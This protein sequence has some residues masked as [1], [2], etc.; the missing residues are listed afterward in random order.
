MEASLK[1]LPAS[2]KRPLAFQGALTRIVKCLLGILV[3]VLA[4]GC[5]GNPQAA[6][7][8]R[9]EEITGSGKLVT[10]ELSLSGF[11]GVEV[12]SAFKVDVFQSDSY[13]VLVT[14]D[15]NIIDRVDAGVT[16]GRLTL[17][18]S[19]GSYL[20][21]TY[22]AS[23]GMPGL[24]SLELSEATTGTVS[25]FRSSDGLEIR[26]GGASRLTGRLEAGQVRLVPGEA[27]VVTL[28]GRAESLTVEGSGASEANLGDWAVG[29]ARVILRE[30]SKATVNVA[31]GLDADLRAASTLNYVGNPT[32]GSVTSVEASSLR[33]R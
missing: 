1:A 3:V 20:S 7:V 16:G 2:V 13:Q 17:G 27:S 26:L 5:G 19:P 23:V 6:P 14:A 31:G 24:R 10:R 29:S 18:M 25:G 33:R 8:S 30:A 32:L 15:D 12:R 22:R 9:A 4:V 21:A 11:T 28:G